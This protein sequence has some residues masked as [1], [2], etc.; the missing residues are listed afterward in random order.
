[1]RERGEGVGD[2]DQVIAARWQ[3][4]ATQAFEEIQAWRRQHPT[5]T[6]REIEE[7][8]DEHLARLRAQVVQG[9]ALTSPLADLRGVPLQERPPCPHCGARLRPRGQHRRRL[10]TSQEQPVVLERPYAEC[11]ACGAG[12]FPLDDELAVLPGC[13]TPWLHT[14]LVELGTRLPFAVAARELAAS[15]HVHLSEATA[16]RMTEQAGAASVAVQT[17]EAEALA[18]AAPAAPAGPARQLLSVDGAMVPLVGGGWTEVKTL[19]MG[20]LGAPVWEE[21]QGE[22]VGHATHLA[23]FS[24]HAEAATFSRLATVETHGRGTATAGVVCAVTDGAEWAQGFIDAHCPGAVRILDFPH[25]AH[26]LGTVAAVVGAAGLAEPAAWLA[27]QC[28]ELKHG[29]PAVVLDRLRTLAA[30]LAP[31]AATA[32]ATV[33]QCVGYLEPRQG[34]IQYAAFQAA[35]YPLGSG[36]VESANKLV[37]EARLKGAGM[38]WAVAH[39]NPM[40]AVRTVACAERWAAAWPRITPPR[41]ARRR[42]DPAAPPATPVAVAGP[43]VPVAAAAGGGAGVAQAAALVAQQPTSRDQPPPAP[44]LAPSVVPAA[45]GPRRPGPT[46]PWRRARAGRAQRE[47]AA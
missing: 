29:E 21:H 36:A 7:A 35:G 13:L 22:W 16:R 3:A 12:L 26:A 9:T 30:A 25:A 47:V 32:A 34:Q 1:M 43:A 4:L 18:R 8:L 33:R 11:P 14:R 17:T 31:G 41:R 40:V 5:V 38:H 19:A 44:P 39:V 6:L 20:D 46:H 2:D 24:R 15:H 28:H 27:T 23:Y 10:T 37:V 42:S 45:T